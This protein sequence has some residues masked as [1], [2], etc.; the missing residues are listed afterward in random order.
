MVHGRSDRDE[1]IGN[2]KVFKAIAE[3]LSEHGIAVLR[4]DKRGCGESTGDYST[5]NLNQYASDV[6]AAINYL[7]NRK[8]LTIKILINRP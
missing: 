5:S 3:H 8:I 7:K 2:N 1:T 4:Y 6:I